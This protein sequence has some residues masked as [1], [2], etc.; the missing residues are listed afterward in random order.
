MQH[1][2]RYLEARLVLAAGQGWVAEWKIAVV[3]TGLGLVAGAAAVWQGL[4]YLR[5]VQ[6]LVH[7]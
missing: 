4:L 3:M 1:E 2:L 7:I 6:G 5:D